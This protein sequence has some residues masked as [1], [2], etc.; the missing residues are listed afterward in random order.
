MELF[1][2]EWFELCDRFDEHFGCVAPDMLN[3]CGQLSYDCRATKKSYKLQILTLE[4][5]INLMQKSLET[6]VDHLY[7]AVKD[8]PVPPLP[9]GCYS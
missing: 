8:H 7:E 4:E 2:K 5:I 6:G 1:D 9:P 3:C